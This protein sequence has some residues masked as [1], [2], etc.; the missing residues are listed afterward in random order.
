MSSGAEKVATACADPALLDRDRSLRHMSTALRPRLLDMGG[1][2]SD[3]EQTPA[4]GRSAD[5][6]GETDHIAAAAQAAGF[7]A[8]LVVPAR[9]GADAGPG[10]FI[11][12]THRTGP[13]FRAY[14]V[15]HG[16]ALAY[17]ATQSQMHLGFLQRSLGG[18]PKGPL[19]RREREVLSLSA[20]GLTTRDVGE[21][22]GISVSGVNFHIANAAR[23]LGA[24]NRTHATS[25]A[26]A[27]GHISL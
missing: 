3:P 6:D 27:A 22:L 18:N 5:P 25:L 11:L 10:G 17:A 15:E 21:A 4:P 24:N 2:A 19:T 26:L 9:F 14:T 20:R 12:L 8:G 16:L 13:Q 1:A 23:K 7:G